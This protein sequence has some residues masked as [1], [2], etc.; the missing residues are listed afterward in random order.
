MLIFQHFRLF[1]KHY[2]IEWLSL[3]RISIHGTI[4]MSPMRA[5]SNVD[6]YLRQISALPY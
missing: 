5:I 6:K 2:I 4:E 1:E 3:H